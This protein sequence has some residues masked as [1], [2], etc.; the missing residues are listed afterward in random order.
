MKLKKSRKGLALI[1]LY[2]AVFGT[3]ILFL[4]VLIMITAGIV[5]GLIAGLVLGVILGVIGGELEFIEHRKI[6]RKK[7][8]RKKREEPSAE[9]RIIV[10]PGTPSD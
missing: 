4:I 6:L 3:V 5:P 10:F 2:Y 8:D 9:A 1:I 7:R